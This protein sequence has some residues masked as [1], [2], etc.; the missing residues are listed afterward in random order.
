MSID[1]IK[2][3]VPDKLTFFFDPGYVRYRN[4]EIYYKFPEDL[5]KADGYCILP[6]DCY[7]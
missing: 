5:K 4:G 1:G 3:E 6:A 2:I 7:I